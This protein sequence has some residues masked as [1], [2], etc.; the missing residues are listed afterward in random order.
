MSIQHLCNPSPSEQKL[1]INC[2]NVNCNNIAATGNLG[3][4]VINCGG[5]T[6]STI[7]GDAV[8]AGAVQVD[9]AVNCAL[10]NAGSVICT[11]LTVSENAMLFDATKAQAKIT[12]NINWL[13]TDSIFKSIVSQDTLTHFVRHY[14]YIIQWSC[15]SDFTASA[16][17]FQVEESNY[18]IRGYETKF[19]VVN[20]GS[21]NLIYF[22]AMSDFSSNT[23]NASWA[24][25]PV[26]TA[27]SSGYVYVDFHMVKA[28]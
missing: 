5:I 4:P 8:Y 28:K 25:T 21:N 18:Q 17:T 14:R 19:D 26:I 7:T 11:K 9:E 10:C 6:S 2:A 23:V 22:G 12:S 15:I 24:F 27:G 13:L 1:D 20:P 3:I 16:I